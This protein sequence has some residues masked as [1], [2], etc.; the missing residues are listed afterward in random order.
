MAMTL[1]EIAVRF[2]LELAGDPGLVVDG[3]AALAPGS[4]IASASPEASKTSRVA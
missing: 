4:E 2:G 1:G 3:V